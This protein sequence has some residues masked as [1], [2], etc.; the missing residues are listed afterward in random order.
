[1]SMLRSIFNKIID[2]VDI[3]LAITGCILSIP[4]TVYLVNTIGRPLF[5]TVAII[6]ACSFFLYLIIRLKSVP[7]IVMELELNSSVYLLLNFLFFS[8]LSYSILALYCSA[9]IYNRPLGYFISTATMAAVLA[10]EILFLPADRARTYFILFKIIIIGLSLIYSQLLTF[11]SIVGADAWTHQR[12]TLEMLQQGYSSGSTGYFRM[13]SFHLIVGETMLLTGL[14]YKMAAMLSVTL[15]QV[16]CNTLF[17]FLLGRLI[18]DVKVGLLGSLFLS[19]ATWQIWFGYWT[20]PNTMAAIFI[21]IVVYLL[22]RN[23]GGKLIS[24]YSLSAVFM[25]VLMFTHAVVTV[26]LGLLLFLLWLGYEIYRRLQDKSAAPHPAIFVALVLFSAA[27]LSYWIFFSHHI[28]TIL[29][30]IKADFSAE[31][32]GE[33]APHVASSIDVTLLPEGF[34]PLSVAI[35]Q[36]RDSIP[37]PEQLFNQLGFFLYFGLGFIGSFILLSRDIRN[38]HSFALVF[39]GLLILAITFIAIVTY[40]GLLPGRWNYFC[41]I[42]LAIPVGAAIIWFGVL[43]LKKV[44]KAVVVGL[45]SFIL[46]FLMIMSPLANMDNR[47]FSPMSIVRYGYTESEMQ[48]TVTA[49]SIYDGKIGVDDQYAR[50]LL[51]QQGY[52][53]SGIVMLGKRIYYQFFGDYPQMLVLI[54]D[55]IVHNTFEL[56][57]PYQL[58]Y[59]PEEVL[60]RKGYSKVYENGSVGGFFNSWGRPDDL[61]S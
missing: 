10:I 58:E 46:T 27:T 45:V 59:D 60:D 39:S 26:W 23:Q 56:S 44:A 17:I 16:I 4:L 19:V 5:T 43:P 34:Q 54:R 50:P 40:L 18:A 53:K 35:A 41:Q 6:S 24:F 3:S 7:S 20:I 42:L 55:E 38:R 61:A 29:H 21:P 13:P 11:P 12:A 2:N 30:L 8:L 49:A 32:F 33:I 48:A 25:L 14:E 15:F 51:Y 47:T 9:D 1:M 28:N 31:Y 36:Y 52:D 22:L 37:V 57:G